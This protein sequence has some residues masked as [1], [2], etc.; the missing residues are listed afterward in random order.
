MAKAKAVLARNDRGDYTVPSLQ[1]YPHQWLWDS[2][3]I[4]IGQ[5]HYD[6]DRA[7]R[8]LTSLVK[9]QWRNGMMPHII[10]DPAAGYWLDHNFWKSGLSP[11]SPKDVFTSG[12]SQPPVVALAVEAVAGKLEGQSRQKFIDLMLPALIA[13]HR[14]WYRERDPRNTGLVVL[15][16][17][18]ENGLDNTPPWMVAL[19]KVRLPV[20]MRAGLA[21]Q[22]PILL[23]K[24][25]PDTK[26]VSANQRLKASDAARALILAQHLRQQKYD[27]ARILQD[28][29]VAIESLTTN[30][31][32]VAA[33]ESLEQVAQ[34]A[35]ATVPVDLAAKA[36]QTKAAL[37]ALYQDGQYYSRNFI[38]GRLIKT[39]SLN[40]FFPLLAGVASEEQASQ[41]VELLKD[42]KQYWPAYPVPSVP[43][44]SPSFDERRYWQGPTWIN[45]NWLIMKGLRRYGYNQE[46]DE[47]K[48]RSL[49]L[50]AKS[51]FGEYFSPLTGERYGIDN[52]AWT[53]ALTI[54]LLE[55]N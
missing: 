16:H 41:L 30:C 32:L 44:I 9:G 20:W 49:E 37:N 21:L 39:P 23:K 48:R 46:A 18:W 10:F 45:T 12:I 29:D 43:V 51:G 26:I 33:A 52:F 25:R 28:P 38:T 36:A 6:P 31:I 24:L 54:D 42:Q 1:I 17:I 3:F 5:A 13:Y 19:N 7:A 11:D 55:S 22:L 2:A 35:G 8:E 53:A 40:T 34:M 47:L 50:V 15:V 4:A 14:W 27:S